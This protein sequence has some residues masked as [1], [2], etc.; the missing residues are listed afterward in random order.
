MNIIGDRNYFNVDY[1]YPGEEFRDIK[2]YEGRYMVSNYGRILSK[3]HKLS[4]TDII[5]KPK[6]QNNYVMMTLF[7]KRVSPRRKDYLGHRAV[8]DA[9]VEGKSEINCTVNHKDFNRLN[10]HYL[11]LEWCSMRANMQHAHRNKRI[12]YVRGEDKNMGKLKESD[13]YEIRDM[14]VRGLPYYIMAEKYNVSSALISC[15]KMERVWAHLNLN[16]K[17]LPPLQYNGSHGRKKKLSPED[18]VEIKKSLKMGVTSASLGRKYNVTRG[19]ILAIK[20]KLAWK[21]IKI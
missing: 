11:N 9:F 4:R 2:G 12:T 5:L 13:V 6:I 21:H 17:H 14:I 15:I 7:D 16:I 20:H 19:A 10:N 1:R 8:A 3:I 18:V